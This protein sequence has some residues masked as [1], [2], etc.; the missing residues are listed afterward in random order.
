[1]L[2]NCLGYLFGSLYTL[3]IAQGHTFLH[4]GFYAIKSVY[5]SFVTFPPHF[6]IIDYSH[7]Y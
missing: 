3:L 1:M 2:V 5:C 4:V 6:G 7:Y